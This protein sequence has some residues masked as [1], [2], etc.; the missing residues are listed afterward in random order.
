[1]PGFRRIDPVKPRVSG[2]SRNMGAT[3][4]FPVSEGS[5]R[6]ILC[7][8]KHCPRGQRAGISWTDDV[9]LSRE[10]LDQLLTDRNPRSALD[11]GGRVRDLT[12]APARFISGYASLSGVEM[13]VRIP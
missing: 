11:S 9:G 5:V 4:P 10:L 2:K 7:S 3:A 8:A 6:K 13:S 1:M 12:K